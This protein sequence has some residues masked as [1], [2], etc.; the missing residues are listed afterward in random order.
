MEREL[1]EMRDAFTEWMKEDDNFF[2]F[3]VVCIGEGVRMSMEDMEKG[4]DSELA[5]AF[6]Q[7]YEKIT[8][9]NFKS[10]SD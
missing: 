10:F 7:V 6:K 8:E 9:L 4:E 1:E 2:S 3:V 5:R